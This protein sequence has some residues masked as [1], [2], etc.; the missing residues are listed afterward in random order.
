MEA[1]ESFDLERIL[2]RVAA[3]PETPATGDARLDVIT[4]HAAKLTL[5]PTEMTE[6][7][8]RQLRGVGFD[9]ATSFAKAF[10]RWT[11]ESPTA[12]QARAV[13]RRDPLG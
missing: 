11:G 2:D 8:I 13:E 7:D 10:R 4:A 6:D 1:F 5:E 12:Y 3:R 9:D